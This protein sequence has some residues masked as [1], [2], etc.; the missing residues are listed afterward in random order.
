MIAVTGAR[1]RTLDVEA[2][3]ARG[4]V[5]CNTGG[6]RASAATAELTLGLLIAA[7]RFVPVADASMRASRFQAGVP[8]GT[9]LEGRTL[10][11]IGVGKIGT[12]MARFGHALGMRVLG[13]SPNL[14]PERAQSAGAQ[15][16]DKAT[17]LAESD[18]VSLHLVLSERT[19]GVLGRE[20]LARMKAGAI[21]VNTSRGPLVDEAALVE[22]LRSGTL[23]AALDV[24][25][26]E[27]LPVDHPL[28]T[29]PNTVLT[30][31]L[32]YCTHE[33]YAQFYRESIENTLAFLDG[34]PIRVLNP[35]ALR[36][37]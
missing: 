23:I 17:L 1:T 18:A 11:I 27:P 7:A 14:T 12:R 10:G 15:F 36:S 35:E 28:R 25:G 32:G 29:L 13:W 21:L 19:R 16:A 5:V 33:V 22:K 20:D 31:H 9:A 30:P 8:P 26:Q 6:D 24:Y 34:K 4:I 2:C 3:S 37:V